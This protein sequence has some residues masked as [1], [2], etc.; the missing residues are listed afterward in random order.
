[1]KKKMNKIENNQEY[2]FRAKGVKVVK[3]TNI[4]L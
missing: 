1:M 4:Q 2:H 3:K